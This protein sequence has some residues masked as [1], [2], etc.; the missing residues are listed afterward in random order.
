MSAAVL[1]TLASGR[2]G[3]S[4]TAFSEEAH[5]IANII[6][7]PDIFTFFVAACAGTAGV[8]RLGTA[9]S[10]ALIG[11]L[12]STTAIPAAAIQRGR[13]LPGL[14][15]LTRQHGAAAD[16][17]RVDRHRRQRGAPP[18]AM[19]LRASQAAAHGRSRTP[20]SRSR[21]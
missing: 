20:G 9:K 3:C 6:A 5:S 11:V 19:A 8:L 14:A 2:P 1:A 7:E 18:A 4:S 21:R 10:G 16:Q 17:R 15:E 13:G 12:I